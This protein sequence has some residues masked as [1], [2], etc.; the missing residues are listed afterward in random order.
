MFYDDDY[1]DLQKAWKKGGIG[2]R[3]AS[4]RLRKMKMEASGG[5]QA[6]K[7]KARRIKYA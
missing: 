2:W 6:R 1:N 7:R 3:N 4:F 5:S